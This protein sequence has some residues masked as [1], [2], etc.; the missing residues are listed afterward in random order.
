M[1]QDHSNGH[2]QNILESVYQPDKKADYISSIDPIILRSWQRCVRH[3]NLEP[4]DSRGARVLTQQELKDYRLP[5]EEFLHIAKSGLREVYKQ[6]NAL[7][8]VVLLT[9]HNGITVDYLGNDKF[10]DELKSC[11][12]YLG[13]DWNERNSG[14]SGVGICA[15]EMTPVTVHHEDHFDLKNTTLSCTAAPI[16]DPEGKPLAVLDVSALNSPKNKESQYLLLQLVQQHALNIENA[17]ILH[18]YQKNNWIVRFGAFKDYVNV[19][20]TNILAIDETGVIKGLNTSA[21]KLLSKTSNFRDKNWNDAVG[22]SITNFFDCELE[23]LIK[24]QNDPDRC[25]KPVKIKISGE[26]IYFSSSLPLS[27][28]CSFKVPVQTAST[29]VINHNANNLSLDEL[30]DSDPVLL[31]SIKLAKRLI[32][33]NIS[34][35]IQGETGTGKEVFAR[36]IH[37][38]R[39]SSSKPFIAVN[40]AAIPESLIESELFGYKPGTFTGARSKGMTGLIQKSSGG[41]LFLDEIGDMPLNLQTRLLRVLSEQE[42]M[43]LGCDKPIPVNLNVISATHK[44]IENMIH[45]GKFRE[46][47]YFRLAGATL[48]LPSLRE[49]KDKEFIIR[50]AIQIESNSTGIEIT[51]DTLEL[52]MA[53]HWPGNIRELRNLLR[54]AIAFSDQQIITKEDLPD[55]FIMRLK[56]TYHTTPITNQNSIANSS[57]LTK[58][59]D[60]KVEKLV[61]CLKKN[62]WN[63]TDTS[64]ELNISRATIYRKMKKYNIVTPNEM[65][66]EI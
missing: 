66:Y 17:N 36:A 56:S 11:G 58:K 9:D 64:N 47:L 16:F 52:L 53:Y 27:Q 12:L 55:E 23:D 42:V 14:T 44:H 26:R 62:K 2:V 5:V 28:K 4:S 51:G 18:H 24:I 1:I 31:K 29:S 10:D 35:L 34:F 30:T 49:R 65:E 19:N 50:K 40:C 20:T 45:E 13:A 63:I 32:N 33:S 43:P 59:L 57:P 61:Q 8:Y 15:T 48:M 25:I 39:H 46:D 41:S 21:R 7:D 3:Y 22:K 60:P 6:V 54:V 37:N 38:E